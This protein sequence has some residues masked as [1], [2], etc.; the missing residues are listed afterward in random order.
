MADSSK[1]LTFLC[2]FDI[3]YNQL[4]IAIPH[5]IKGGFYNGGFECIKTSGN[6]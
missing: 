1:L 3:M 2:K 5:S 4:H 6:A